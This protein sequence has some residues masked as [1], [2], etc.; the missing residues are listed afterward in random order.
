MKK[1]NNK[2]AALAGLLAASLVL[3][4]CGNG[5]AQTSGGDVSGDGGESAN[6]T[7][8]ADAAG[9][10]SA[11]DM[12]SQYGWTL[13]SD[14]APEAGRDTAESTGTQKDYICVGLRTNPNSLNPYDFG[15]STELCAEVF[16]TL[17]VAD[18]DGDFQGILAKDWEYT[19]DEE[20]TLVV[21]LYENIYDSAQNNLTAEDVVFSFD[22]YV[23]SGNAR[24]FNY[25]DYSEATDTYQVTF[26]WTERITSLDGFDNMM[27]NTYICTKAAY[28]SHNF[29]VDPVGTGPY[30]MTAFESG[31]GF[32]L[33]AREDYWQSADLLH[34]SQKANVKTIE[35]QFIL[36][37]AMRLIALEDGKIS[38][39]ELADTDLDT[40]ETGDYAGQYNLYCYQD[41]QAQTILPNLSGNSIMDDI[42]MR[43]AIFYAIDSEGFAD[44]L[45]S[46]L[47]YPCI[48]DSAPVVGDYQEEW[49]SWDTYQTSYDPDLAMEYL[50]KTDYNN[51]ELVILNENNDEKNTIALVLQGYLEAIGIKS[52][53]E[54]LDHS[55]ID[56]TAGDSTQWDIF[57][58]SV[59]DRDYT[60][61]RFMKTYSSRHGYAQGCTL[62]FSSDEAFEQMLNDNF[63]I[64]TYSADKTTEIMQYIYDNAYGYAGCYAVKV[65]AFDKS[66]AD[67][68]TIA[69]TTN[70][71]MGAC[72]YYLD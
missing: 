45:G 53:V 5:A 19:D 6:V 47:Y 43:L 48:V 62:S 31:A 17:V 7:E 8:A 27:A 22:T 51:E 11:E 35:Y 56:T 9:S 14:V 50:A 28:E 15:A 71:V 57:I 63:S 33:T 67:F 37:N 54:T 3:A 44:A 40:F 41:A 23:A 13:L 69:G 55:L 12:A 68:Y 49:N 34:Q 64:D 52:K 25:Y 4:G 61:E 26:H 1:R 32:T 30:K 72:D 66:I 29:A 36:D 58:Y 24:D 18:G 10:A 42:N 21:N 60:I 70:I 46:R 59:A 38:Y 2:I 39:C 16:E 20:T 65:T